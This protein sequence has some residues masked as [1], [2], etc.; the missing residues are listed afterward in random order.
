MIRL[1]HTDLGPGPA[2]LNIFSLGVK[3]YITKFGLSLI[4]RNIGRTSGCPVQCRLMYIIRLG[5]SNLYG[6]LGSRTWN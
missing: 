2:G 6:Q 1:V 5:E 4:C 3:S